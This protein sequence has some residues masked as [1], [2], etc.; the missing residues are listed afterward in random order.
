MKPGEWKMCKVGLIQYK[1]LFWIYL[2]FQYTH[3]GLVTH[4]CVSKLG[5][6]WFGTKLMPEPKFIIVNL[7]TRK[8]DKNTVMFIQ[9]DACCNVLTNKN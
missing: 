8:N 5:P 9:D 7:A 4:M 3:W 2:I 6:L 1:V